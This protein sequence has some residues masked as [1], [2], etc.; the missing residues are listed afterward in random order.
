MQGKAARACKDNRE[1]IRDCT[2]EIA[3]LESRIPLHRTLE[4]DELDLD[5]FL[6]K[7]ST[8]CGDDERDGICIRHQSDG[9]F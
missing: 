7:V 9:Q 2:V 8:L 6:R 1:K 5:T 3:A 4:G